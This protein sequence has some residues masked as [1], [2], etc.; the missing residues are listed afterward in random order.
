MLLEAGRVGAGASSGNGGWVCPSLCYPVPGPGVLQDGIRWLLRPDG[1][2]RIHLRPDPFLL[3]WLLAFA[4]H[5]NRTDHRRGLEALSRM[6]SS[7]DA[8]FKCLEGDGIEFELHRQGLLLLFRS[9]AAAEQELAALHLMEQF[10]GSAPEWIEGPGLV[11]LEPAV[12]EA[13]GLVGIL[14]P[15]DQHL[16]PESLMLGL[17]RWLASAGVEVRENVKVVAIEPGD[18][19]GRTV[20]TSMGERVQAAAVV[21]ASGV[22]SRSLC[23]SI[24]L[25]LPL[26]GGK[27]YSV[28]FASSRP[29]PTH[30]LYLSEAR[31]AVSPYAREVRVLGT[32]EIGEPGTDA[33]PRRIRAMLR[34]AG[35]YLSGLTLER[36]GQPWAGLRPMVPDGLPVIGAAAEDVVVATG[37]AM[38][39]ITLAPTTGELVADLLDGRPVPDYAAVFSPQRFAGHHL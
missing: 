34:A 9:A 6:A 36:P 18:S 8:D 21:V 26:L 25:N 11:S 24:G 4:G 10:G 38:L 39:G 16:R 2:L 22:G 5:C 19:P 23:R 7:A 29:L 33:N 30:A 3:R 13:D 37:H 15:A 1:P 20:V 32:M 28:T 12:G 17:S 27:G 14:A 35:R 31:V